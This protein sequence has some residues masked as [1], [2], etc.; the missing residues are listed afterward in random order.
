M[1]KHRP[2]KADAWQP[3]L[4]IG[5]ASEAELTAEVVRITAEIVPRLSIESAAAMLAEIDA[6]ILSAPPFVDVHRDRVAPTDLLA[7]RVQQLEMWRV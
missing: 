4:D 7:S 5:K 1:R 3:G 6:A 2:R